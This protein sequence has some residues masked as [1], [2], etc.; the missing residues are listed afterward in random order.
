MKKPHRTGRT[1]LDRA[2]DA[3][4]D[5]DALQESLRSLPR[6]R[7]NAV[8]L[9]RAVSWLRAAQ[10]QSLDDD[11]RFISLWVALNA[12]YAGIDE[13]GGHATKPERE[14]FRRFAR[15]LVERDRGR[16]IYDCLWNEFHGPVRALVESRYLFRDFW[17]FHRTGEGDW[18]AAF[19]RS[20]AAY[21]RGMTH[22]RHT[23]VILQI[24]LDRLYLL[25]N[26]LFHGGATW[27]SRVNRTQVRS[28]NG[29]LAKLV[30]IVVEL[31]FEHLDDDWGPIAY[32]VV[33]N[34]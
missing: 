27:K 31:M 33:D 16:R 32:P 18:E 25:R 15:R 14:R 19:R 28:A 12:C 24:L 8:R 17:I 5:L 34:S 6:S 3:T 4:L 1:T 10:R 26:Q 20:V 29:I 13:P 7:P 30:P 2:G 11:L 23:A 22:G 21:R 9:H